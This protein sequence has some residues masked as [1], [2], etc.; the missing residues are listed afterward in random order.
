MR[1]L[2]PGNMDFK[3]TYAICVS[4]PLKNIFPWCPFWPRD[5]YIDVWIPLRRKIREN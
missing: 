2:L 5:T 3:P 1:G 4:I